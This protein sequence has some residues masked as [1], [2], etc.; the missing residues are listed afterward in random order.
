MSRVFA[1]GPG[2]LGSIPDHV[3]TKTLKMV[4]DSSLLNTQQYKVLNK[5]K[6]E[7]SRERSS[8]LPCFCSPSTTVALNYG[9]QLYLILD[10]SCPIW[11]KL[12][13]MRNIYNHHVAPSARIS[14]TLSCHP[15]PSSIASSRSSGLH[16]VLAQ[17]CCMRF[18]LVFLPLLT[19]V[20]GVHR[21]TSLMS[22][23][24]LLWF[25]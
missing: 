13:S 11:T 7:Q 8:I 1:N 17:S 4:L 20:K 19:H 6:E 23:S 2:D 25:V 3:I 12:N 16:P 15:S 14:L 21:S 24:L 18:K 9:R 22:S 10:K 5:G